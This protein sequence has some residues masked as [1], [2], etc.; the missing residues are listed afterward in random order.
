MSERT[1]KYLDA[2]ERLVKTLLQV[3]ASA[4]IVAWQDDDPLTWQSGLKIAGLAML[5]SLLTSV[6]SWTFGNK[7]TASALPASAD[8]ATPPGQGPE[9][10]STGGRA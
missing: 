2:L 9:A 6:A 10:D 1:R 7:Q 5:F 3:G 4:L 8:P